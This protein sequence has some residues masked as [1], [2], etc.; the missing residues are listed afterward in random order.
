MNVEI[1]L[2]QGHSLDQR[3]KYN[4]KKMAEMRKTA[5][6]ISAPVLRS[7]KVQTSP[8]GDAPFVKAL[9]RIEA[10]EE[11]IKREVDL[12][13]ALMDQINEVISQVDNEQYQLLLMYRYVDNMT[14]EQVGAHLCIGK[15]TAKR[16]K[17]KAL[18]QIVLPENLITI[19]GV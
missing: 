17:E 15:S 13:A 2:K 5:S 18:E 11:R 10:L 7:D 9:E 4:L 8:S 19:R 6:D 3:I 16:W 14:W 12:L 1:Y